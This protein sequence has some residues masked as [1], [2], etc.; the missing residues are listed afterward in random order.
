MAEERRSRI[1]IRVENKDYE[2]AGG[3]FQQILAAVKA[4]PNRR[5]NGQLK[6]WEVS[7]SLAM[8]RGQLEN[9]GFSLEGG[10]PA[11]AGPPAEGT[12]TAG[13][14]RIKIEVA[15]YPMV[16]TGAPFQTMLSAIKE[17]PGR[18]FDG[19]R[20]QWSLPGTLVEIKAHLE[21]KGLALEAQPGE[22][23]PSPLAPADEAFPT[24]PDFFGPAGQQPPPPPPDD[25]FPAN[26]DFYDDIEDFN[27]P[28]DFEETPPPE[29]FPPTSPTSPPA[30][31]PAGRRD[32]IRVI[33]GNRPLVVVGGGF[34]EMLAAI[35]GIPN[36][37]FDGETKQWLLPGD[38]DSV[39]QHLRAKGFRLEE[40]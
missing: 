22:A 11:E 27:D 26:A 29:D 33:V 18:R 3:D 6:L 37:R 28:L 8:V 16:V 13:S 4:L 10:T 23:A 31:S 21:K 17:I 40:G 24:S 34:Q 1:K 2:V 7:G 39:Q 36:R 19:E 14:D 20:R 30:R 32:Q 25:W 5:F 38:L 35:K 12:T 15:G 9:S